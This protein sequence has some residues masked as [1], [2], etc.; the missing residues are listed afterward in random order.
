MMQ[1]GRQW[2]FGFSIESDTPGVLTGQAEADSHLILLAHPIN[3][4]D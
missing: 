1:D 2:L 3:L 4:G